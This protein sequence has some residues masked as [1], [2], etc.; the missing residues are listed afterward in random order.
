M[1]LL[2]YYDIVGREEF[3]RAVFDRL[4]L[5][6]A[7]EGRPPYEIPSTI[8]IL[9]KYRSMA[10]YAVNDVVSGSITLSSVEELNDIFDSSLHTVCADEPSTRIERIDFNAP[11]SVGTY[12]F[13]MSE[14]NTSNLM[15]SH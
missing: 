4:S 5:K 12:V 14:T 8:P 10:D 13:C 7:Q 1:A 3:R 2:T 9:Y 15:W 11:G 6:L